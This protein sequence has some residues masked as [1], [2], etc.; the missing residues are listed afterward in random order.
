[1]R[2]EEGEDV[3]AL[4]S[5]SEE[6]AGRIMSPN[7]FAIPEETSAIE[8]MR[9]LRSKTDV[10]MVFYL[11]VVDERNHLLGVVS[12]RQLILVEPDTPI[13]NIMMT[14]IMSV[15]TDTDQEE[16]ARIV[17]TYDFLAVPVVDDSNR[18]MGIV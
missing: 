5:Y 1:M 8:A 12:L 13:K 6:T 4:L 7:Y 2:Q 10:E 17:S 3:Q 18:L 15:R 16:V 9:A 11:Y 14:N